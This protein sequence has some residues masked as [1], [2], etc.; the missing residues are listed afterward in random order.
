VGGSNDARRPRAIGGEK[1]QRAARGREDEGQQS[2]VLRGQ[3]AVSGDGDDANNRSR[4]GRNDVATVPLRSAACDCA[5]TGISEQRLQRRGQRW[6]GGANDG[7]RRAHTQQQRQA[8]WQRS[9]KGPDGRHRNRLAEG[10]GK[11]APRSNGRGNSGRAGRRGGTVVGHRHQRSTGNNHATRGINGRDR[12]ECPTDRPAARRTAAQKNR[13][14][15]TVA[16]NNSFGTSIQSR[17][18]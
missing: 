3:A 7:P 12:D 5:L 6:R 8:Q 9:Q 13:R 4:R 11:A 17:I 2:S 1:E 10:A 18:H 15:C 16:W 14:G